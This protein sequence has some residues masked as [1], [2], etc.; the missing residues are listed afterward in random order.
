MYRNSY[1]IVKL[2]LVI[3][4]LLVG[5]CSDRFTMHIDATGVSTVIYEAK[6]KSYGKF[7]LHWSRIPSHFCF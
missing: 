5:S 6:P 7:I 1:V 3:L 2:N 4:I